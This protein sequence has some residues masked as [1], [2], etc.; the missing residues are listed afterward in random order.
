MTHQYAS[1]SPPSVKSA[2]FPTIAI[3]DL[4]DAGVLSGT[5]INFL[6]PDAEPFP[7]PRLTHFST[8]NAL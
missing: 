2:L 7:P 1:S 6:L 8:A 3:D 5:I 4:E